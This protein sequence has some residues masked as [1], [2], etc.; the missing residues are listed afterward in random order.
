[1]NRPFLPL[2]LRLLALAGLLCALAP[3][4]TAQ[5]L[6]L[7]SLLANIQQAIEQGEYPQATDWVL[8][9]R[10][11]AQTAAERCQVELEYA[12]LHANLVDPAEGMPATRQAIRY[13]LNCSDSLR[14]AKLY[15]IQ[16][17]L[18][19]YQNEPDSS[20]HAFSQSAATY[21]SL[22][23]TLNAQNARVKIGNI[24]DEMGE[25]RQAQ[26]YYQAYYEAAQQGDNPFFLMNALIYL[27][28]NQIYLQENEAALANA[29]A[30]YAIARRNDYRM[31]QG[32][33][34]NYQALSFEQIG[35]SVV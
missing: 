32:V 31:E 12:R 34:L 21:D 29:K 15:L 8:Q 35:K 18:H 26:P 28:G 6:P 13:C 25:Y 1:M 33:L 23:Q 4:L 7:D 2:T 10:E 11:R 19:Y 9:A 22:G 27:S 30:G 24:L 20:I 14:L 16:G 5:A 17:I 3:K